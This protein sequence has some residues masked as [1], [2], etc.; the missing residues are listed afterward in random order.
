VTVALATRVV[1]NEYRAV[2]IAVPSPTALT[3]PVGDT[4]T[5][6]DANELHSTWFCSVVG[7]LVLNWNTPFN[8]SCT[9][10]GV[11]TSGAMFVLMLPG[12]MVAVPPMPATIGIVDCSHADS[13]T[14]VT[15]MTMNEVRMRIC[16]TESVP[17]QQNS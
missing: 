16:G 12:G 10:V 14:A 8:R 1:S 6:V 2:M 9:L 5:M 7:A 17:P 11:I 3:S 15:E 4:V 13:M